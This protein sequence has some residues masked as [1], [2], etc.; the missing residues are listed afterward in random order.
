MVTVVFLSLENHWLGEWLKKKAH[1]DDEDKK[2][3]LLKNR[4]AVWQLQETTKGGHPQN[5]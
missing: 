1:A 3:L 2:L 5:G 4:L